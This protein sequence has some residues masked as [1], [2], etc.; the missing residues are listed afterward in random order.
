MSN[1]YNVNI[2][3]NCLKGTV[4]P[5]YRFKV[6][7]HNQQETCLS[8]VHVYNSLHEARENARKKKKI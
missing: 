4:T 6:Y 1:N 7:L 2:L 8:Y 5:L 3:E